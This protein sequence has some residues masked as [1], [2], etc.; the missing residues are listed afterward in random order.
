VLYHAAVLI[1]PQLYRPVRTSLRVRGVLI[2]ALGAL[3]LSFMGLFVL[4]GLLIF[5]DAGKSPY[6]G[7]N[8]SEGGAM[9]GIA[10]VPFSIS[11]FILWRGHARWWKAGAYDRLL[12]FAASRPGTSVVEASQ[13]LRIPVAQVASLGQEGMRRGFIQ[14]AE[15]PELRVVNHESASGAAA[16]VPEFKPGGTPLLAAIASYAAGVAVAAILVLAEKTKYERAASVLVTAPSVLLTFTLDT[17]AVVGGISAFAAAKRMRPPTSV[18][19]PVLAIVMGALGYVGV[20][21]LALFGALSLLFGP[22]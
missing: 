12:A 13:S 9:F 10:M 17:V 16:L 7:Q 6:P 14:H 3:G 11:A 20:F 18:A 22:R 5:A 1:D 8:R 19:R 4:G 15:Q 21:A 2:M